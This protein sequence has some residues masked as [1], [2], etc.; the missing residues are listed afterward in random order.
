MHTYRPNIHTTQQAL[1]KISS[2]SK[3]V[4]G[5]PPRSRH[6]APHAF[7]HIHPFSRKIDL[8]MKLFF[9]LTFLNL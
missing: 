2:R 8:W 4:Q 6:K 7:T 5:N 9:D 3:K 1:N